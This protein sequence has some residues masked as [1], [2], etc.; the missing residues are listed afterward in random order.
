MKRIF[1][2]LLVVLAVII[3]LL[4]VS[5][6]SSLS[7]D[8]KV[9]FFDVGQ[10]D[11][12]LIRTPSQQNIIIDGGPDNLFINKLGQTLPFY[13][14][15]IDLMVLT[16]AHDDH[17]FGLIEVLKRYRVKEV[18]YSGALH[19][20][21]AYLQWLKII[22]DKKIPLTIAIVGQEFIFGESK[23]GGNPVKL[24]VLY[25]LKNLANRQ[26]KDLNDSSVVTQ[27]TYGQTK[28]LLMGDLPQAGEGE[29]LKYFQKPDKN[30][31]EL[32]SQVIKIGHH[33]S[34]G[35]S[36]L[37][38]LQ[39]VQPD[40]AVISAGQD[41]KFGHPSARTIRRLKSLGIKIYRT[42]QLGDILFIS[43]GQTLNFS[44]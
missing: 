37:D 26:F 9:Y 4:L 19:T 41:N 13:D 17:L 6:R 14:R 3:I 42:D 11:G 40:F 32:H 7:H 8:L 2:I 29:I 21:D 15:T 39:A 10:G 16:H 24:Q 43:N 44:P 1:K 27:L 22:R 18:L 28:F 30:L 23:S 25:P 5:W 33:G 38:F 31:K 12:M 34:A 35:S 36:A 20:T